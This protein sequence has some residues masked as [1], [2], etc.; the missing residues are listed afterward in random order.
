MDS[1]WKKKRHIL[2]GTKNE[3]KILQRPKLK[4]KYTNLQELKIIKKNY[5]NKK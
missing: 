5:N 2:I 4:K 1:N 3:Q